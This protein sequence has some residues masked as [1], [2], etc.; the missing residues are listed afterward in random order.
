M[1]SK[2]ERCRGDKCELERKG[3]GDSG[4][5]RKA[6]VNLQYRVS[7]NFSVPQ[8]NRRNSSHRLKNKQRQNS[9]HRLKNKQIR[10]S[11]TLCN[12]EHCFIFTFYYVEAF[13]IIFITIINGI[14]YHYIF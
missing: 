3:E 6:S 2:S 8:I 5:K 9:N 11:Q 13:K 10:Y 7:I 4:L 1:Q 12:F 14:F